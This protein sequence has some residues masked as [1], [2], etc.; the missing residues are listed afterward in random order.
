MATFSE[1]LWPRFYGH[2]SSA[3]AYLKCGHKN[4]AI[5]FQKMWPYRQPLL[6]LLQE[7]GEQDQ[8]SNTIEKWYCI[9]S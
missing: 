4:V 7:G 1:N 2:I 8:L 5:S 6:L 3:T 9:F